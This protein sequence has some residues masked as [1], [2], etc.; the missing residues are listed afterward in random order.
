MGLDRRMLGKAFIEAHMI[1]HKSNETFRRCMS[2]PDRGIVYCFLF[3]DDP[4]P[5]EERKGHLTAMCHVARSKNKDKMIIGIATEQHIR[6]TCSYDFALFK[7][8]E[9]S[10]VDQKVLEDLES[11]TDILKSPNKLTIH[12]DE[13]PNC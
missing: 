1:A 10:E 8:H 11:Q 12:E 2:M 9:W 7:V 3:Q 4:E 6:P 5:R 13:Y